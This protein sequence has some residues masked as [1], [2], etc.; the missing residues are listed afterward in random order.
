MVRWLHALNVRWFKFV[1]RETGL[2]IT[3]SYLRQ[4]NVRQRQINN[5]LYCMNSVMLCKWSFSVKTTGLEDN[6]NTIIIQYSIMQYN[7]YCIQSTSRPLSF[8]FSRGEHIFFF[9]GYMW[10]KF[11][12]QKRST[13]WSI[14]DSRGHDLAWKSTE[15][16]KSSF[17]SL[18]EPDMPC[19]KKEQVPCWICGTRQQHGMELAG[20]K[21]SFCK[22]MLL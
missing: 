15:E 3:A 4:S 11:S 10:P 9:L 2:Y 19:L 7:K 6:N 5:P 16:F 12:F 20:L 18:Q 13:V 8:C 22:S 17:G 1:R 14:L 21:P